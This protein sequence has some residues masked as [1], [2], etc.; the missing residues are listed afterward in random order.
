MKNIPIFII[1]VLVS[2]LFVFP[3]IN[4]AGTS[5]ESSSGS[6]EPATTQ[7]ETARTNENNNIERETG[8]VRAINASENRS[9]RAKQVLAQLLA[10]EG[11]ENRTERIECKLKIRDKEEYEEETE[12]VP[13]A[14]KKLQNKEDCKKL[15]KAVRLCY[16]LEGRAKDKCFKR[17][18]GFINSNLNEERSDRAGKARKYIIFL[19]YDLQEKIEKSV[20][21]EKLNETIGANLIEQIT[22][23]K[24]DIL[25]NKTRQEIKP[26][27][28]EFKKSF[29]EAIKS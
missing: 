19:L 5:S 11:V 8:I 20:E 27:I 15:H 14:C 29:K 2:S 26:K 13:E 9:E 22:S 16:E 4:A 1:L 7:I 25:T 24:E 10:C 23:L 12:R 18:A 21:E 28:I 6:S 17:V 3:I